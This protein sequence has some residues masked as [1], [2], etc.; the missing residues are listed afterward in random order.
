M[1]KRSFQKVEYV[2]AWEKKRLS[3]YTKMIPDATEKNK[4]TT[5]SSLSPH[6]SLG[7]F[8]AVKLSAG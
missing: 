6:I 8:V 4:C 3:G 2:S 1:K 7:D 5:T